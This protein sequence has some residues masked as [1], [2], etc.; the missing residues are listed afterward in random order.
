MFA[1]SQDLETLQEKDALY[2]KISIENDVLRFRSLDS[3]EETMKYLNS[4][5]L[6]KL[7][8]FEEKIGFFNSLRSR[9]MV[10]EDVEIPEAITSINVKDLRLASVINIRGVY[11]IGNTIHKITDDFEYAVE[12][13]NEQILE[14]AISGKETNKFIKHKITGFTS[15]SEGDVRFSGKESQ[16]IALANDP[17]GNSKRA[18][19]EAWSRNYLTYASNGVNLITESYRKTCG[20]CSRKWRDSAVQYM[21]V[22]VTSRQYSSV[23]GTGFW[24]ILNESEEA[25]NYHYIQEVMDYVAGPG[26]WID[27]DYIDCTYTTIDDNNVRRDIFI[28]WTN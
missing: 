13:G 21:K 2:S 23:T 20:L 11:Y 19:M 6:S 7:A 1:C 10:P 27:T 9:L 16:T 22:E 17:G 15:S 14:D 24:F 25:T 5:P 4:I 8:D 28:H 3:F 18:T 12:G 26:V